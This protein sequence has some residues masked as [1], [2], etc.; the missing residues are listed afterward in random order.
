MLLSE[1]A[2]AT[3]GVD[4]GIVGRLQAPAAPTHIGAAWSLLDEAEC[5]R[6]S[7]VAGVLLELHAAGGGRA[8]GVDAQAGV[9]GHEVVV[10]VAEG[11]GCEQL[12]GVAGAAVGPQLQQGPVGGGLYHSGDFPA[13][14]GGLGVVVDNLSVPRS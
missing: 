13:F 7:A 4:A 6:A 14:Y 5:L 9:V 11:F 10:A 3:G 1:P 2:C 8:G 12:V